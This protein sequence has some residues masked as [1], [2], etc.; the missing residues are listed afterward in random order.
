MKRLTSILVEPPTTPIL[1]PLWH[2]TPT[3][4]VQGNTLKRV[5]SN[6][7][8]CVFASYRDRVRFVLGT[9]SRGKRTCIGRVHSVI[10]PSWWIMAAVWEIHKRSAVLLHI[11][12]GFVARIWFAHLI[13][14]SPL[15]PS[16]PTGVLSAVEFSYLSPYWLLWAP[17]LYLHTNIPGWVCLGYCC[18]KWEHFLWHPCARRLCRPTT[19]P[20]L[21]LRLFAVSRTWRVGVMNPDLVEVG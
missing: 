19:S 1:S 14:L 5:H 13:C 21:S 10:E 9:C 18:T 4:S 7:S 12:P 15:R 6:L 17:T 11:T 3:L 20:C 8:W 2:D 16:V